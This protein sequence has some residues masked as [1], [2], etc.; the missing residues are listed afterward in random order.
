MAEFNNIPFAADKR[1]SC[2][3]EAVCIDT[4]RVFDS[5]A[6]RN[7]LEDLRVYFTDATQ[8]LIDAASTVK[9]RSCDIL[10]VFIDVESVPFNR[11]FYSIDLTFFFRCVLDVYTASLTPPTTVEGLAIFTKKC[12]LYGSDGSVKVFSSEYS[13]DEM[14]EQYPVVNNNPRA[15]LQAADPIVLDT[16]LCEECNS[17]CVPCPCPPRPVCRCFNGDFENV[18]GEKMVLVTL[19]LF[20]I[21]QLER[22]VQILIPAYDYC[23]PSKE[24]ACSD[25]TVNPCDVFRKLSFP[26][27]EFFPVDADDASCGC[28]CG[29]EKEEVE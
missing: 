28:G 5:C 24:C 13:A 29:C 14:D 18:Q 22:N 9:C 11:G 17:C 16:Q 21:V 6:D 2:F 8:P 3:K 15:V 10:N 19:G 23:I 26:V 7:C 4:A 20:T 1:D 25:S 12:I 27:D